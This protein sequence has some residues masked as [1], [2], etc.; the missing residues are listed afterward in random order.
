M[1]PQPIP[2]LF[3]F[4]FA[5][6]IF[7]GA[8]IESRS[9]PVCS[10][11]L[12]PEFMQKPIVVVGSINLDLVVGAKRIPQVGETVVGH[13]FNT[14]FGG[15]GANQAVAAAKLG[16][17]VSMVGNVGSDSFGAQLREGLN[18]VGV[19]TAYVNTVEG[20]SGVA[21]ITTGSHGENNIVV[22]PGANGRLTPSSL[23]KAKPIMQSA[24]FLLAQL[25]IPMET[26]EYLA[27]FA[28]GH[29]IPLMLD[30]AP[31][32]ELSPNLLRRVSWITPNE[33]EA[34][35]LLGTGIEDDYQAADAAADLL[36]S[37]G[38]K[39]VLL[40]LGARGCVIAQA[41]LGK[42]RVPAFSVK[43]VDTTAAGDAFNAG[44]AASLM[45][46]AS[47]RDSAVFASAVSAI[48]VTR[49]GAQPSMP[50]RAEVESFLSE[51]SLTTQ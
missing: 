21:L 41:G 19:G 11:S 50:S 40:K 20:P 16:Y 9:R 46:G 25:E 43:A 30:P 39:N 8:E 22:V 1:G 48:S 4:L 49:A 14:F 26:V 42:E 33:T 51:R 2:A 36:L 38:L 34:K 37:Q 35:Q 6:M 3:I 12:R 7:A 13:S 24:G 29:G 15:K 5:G 17:P 18:A 32:R 44:F 27:E 47:V 45:R 28:E 10:S 31:A 23:E